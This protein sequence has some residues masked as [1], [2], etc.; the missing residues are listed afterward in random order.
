MKL[1]LVLSLTV[2]WSCW[3]WFFLL[4]N[5]SEFV[6][7]MWWYSKRMRY[8]KRGLIINNLNPDSN[9]SFRSLMLGNLL[10]DRYTSIIH[11]FYLFTER[12]GEYQNEILLLNC[13]TCVSVE[14]AWT[15]M[16]ETHFSSDLFIS[17]EKDKTSSFPKSLC[18]FVLLSAILNYRVNVIEHRPTLLLRNQILFMY[19]LETFISFIRIGFRSLQQKNKL[20]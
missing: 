18:Y 15:W 1:F 13:V 14:K 20:S 2:L 11:A 5:K 3:K 16:K 7:K 17:K 10:S 4:E 9:L 8:P 19:I 12:Y 6:V